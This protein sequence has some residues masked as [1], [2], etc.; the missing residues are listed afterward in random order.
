MSKVSA[1]FTKKEL[2]CPCCGRTAVEAQVLSEKEFLRIVQKLENLRTAFGGTP[3]KIT[4]SF[5]CP[6]HNKAVG[7]APSSMHMKG[8]AF[9]IEAVGHNALAL[10]YTASVAGWNGIG[11]NPKRNFVHIDDRPGGGVLFTY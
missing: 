5:R 1:N 7:G 11:L 6:A 4:S 2:S 9:D 3:L 10:A 8:I